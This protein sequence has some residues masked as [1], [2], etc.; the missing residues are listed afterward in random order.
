MAAKK[1]VDQSRTEWVKKGTIVNGTAVT[2]GYVAQ[3]GNPAKKVK[4]DVKLAV[5]TKGRGKAGDVV[6]VNKPKKDAAKKPVV[7]TKKPIVKNDTKKAAP[8]S[9]AAK[10]KAISKDRKVSEKAGAAATKK[11]V[12]KNASALDKAKARPTAK[13][14]DASKPLPKG[15]SRDQIQAHNDAIRKAPL[16]DFIANI[17]KGG[18]KPTPNAKNMNVA[19]WQKGTAPKP[20]PK[21]DEPSPRSRGVKN[22]GIMG[23]TK[24]NKGK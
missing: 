21:T 12:V 5:D 8:K 22:A 13:M 6:S 11:Q 15:A 18:G 16:K 1:V 2:K 19:S 10:A 3:K 23:W 20:K 7:A 24:G 4:A 17:G 14:P 9:D